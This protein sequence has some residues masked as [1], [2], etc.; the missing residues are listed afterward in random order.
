MCDWLWH[1]PYWEPDLACNPGMYPDWESNQRPFGLQ[2][3]AQST[4]PHQPGLQRSLKGEIEEP[5]LNEKWRAGRVLAWVGH[6]LRGHRL[7]S[8]RRTQRCIEGSEC[9][10]GFVHREWEMPVGHLG[11]AASMGMGWDL[12]GDLAA[13]TSEDLPLKTVTL[14]IL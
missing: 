8:E 10:F 7:S 2:A 14:V 11:G 6:R 13:P 12:T 9:N 4:E 1:T 5:G 3:G